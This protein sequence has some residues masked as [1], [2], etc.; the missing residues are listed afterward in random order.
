[1]AHS[2][3]ATKAWVS[4]IPTKNADGEVMEWQLKYKYTLAVSGK[5]DYVHIFERKIKIENP[6]KAPDSYT[7]SE[8]L[9]L[10]DLEQM[11][12]TFDQKYAAWIAAES[13]K[14]VDNSFDVTGLND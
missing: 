14:T 4:A 1:M 9:N 10:A 7:K 13:V 2:D 6:S 3:N 11:N 12:L 5:A 8:L